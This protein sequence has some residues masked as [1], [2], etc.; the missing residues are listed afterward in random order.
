MTTL[1]TGDSLT[2]QAPKITRTALAL[3]AGASGDHNPVH[4]DT[5]AC[6][7]VGIP[8]VFAHGMLSMAYLG[9]LLTDWVPQERIRTFAVRFCAITP[10]NATPVCKGVVTRVEDGLAHLD[11]TVTLPEGTVTLE[12]SAVVTAAN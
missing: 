6:A 5:D 9:R 2:L 12:G 1:S 11:L 4:I 10:V 8:D 3:Y 7:T